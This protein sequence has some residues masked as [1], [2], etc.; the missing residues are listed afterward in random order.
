MSATPLTRTTRQPAVG[1]FRRARLAKRDLDLA[2]RQAL[3]LKVAERLVQVMTETHDFI[4]DAREQRQSWK[5]RLRTEL[6][7]FRVSL[8]EDTIAS[9]TQFQS[10][11]LSSAETDQAKRASDLEKLRDDVVRIVSADFF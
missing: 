4:A 7:G 3:L 11:R 2:E 1:R 10:K 9:L 5:E 6:A 8:R